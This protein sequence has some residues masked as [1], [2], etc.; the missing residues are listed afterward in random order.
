MSDEKQYE[1]VESLA[2][3]RLRRGS[4]GLSPSLDSYTDVLSLA[5]DVRRW[6]E[7]E[8]AATSLESGAGFGGRDMN[9]YIDGVEY[10]ISVGLSNEERANRGLP[11]VW[12]YDNDSL[13]VIKEAAR[14]E[15][16]EACAN[17]IENVVA[18]ASYDTQAWVRVA[19]KQIRRGEE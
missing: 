9:F 4:A 8:K 6:L 7:A 16:R 3:A 5:E 14:G 12:L 19:L 2:N 17:L 10:W 15:T 1:N 11:M 13:E 18:N